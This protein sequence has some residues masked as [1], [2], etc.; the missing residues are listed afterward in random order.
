MSK[1]RLDD[2]INVTFA[3]TEAMKQKK[4]NDMFGRLNTSMA[5]ANS[6]DDLFK[7]EK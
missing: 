5:E 6:A 7:S 1:F 4:I 2:M 3:N